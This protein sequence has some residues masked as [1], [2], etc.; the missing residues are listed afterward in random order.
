[1]TINLNRKLLSPKL[2]ARISRTRSVSFGSR[3][4]GTF[5]PVEASW[6][7]AQRALFP[8]AVVT[9]HQPSYPRH[10]RHLTSKKRTLYKPFALGH[11]KDLL[12][13]LSVRNPASP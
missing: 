5:F 1:M 6:Y 12:P 10:S 4:R 2:L 8:E 13:I 9:L 7:R 11:I 3:S